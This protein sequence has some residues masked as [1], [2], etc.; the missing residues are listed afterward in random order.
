VECFMARWYPC[1]FQL[2]LARWFFRCPVYKVSF[3]FS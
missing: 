1:L 2:P 3:Q